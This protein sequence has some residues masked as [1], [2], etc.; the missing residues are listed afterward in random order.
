[1]GR[2]VED[3]SNLS[4]ERGEEGEV[5]RGTSTMSGGGQ[6]GRESRLTL[7]VNRVKEGNVVFSSLIEI[8]LMSFP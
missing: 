8:F 3:G 6:I 2:N 5:E 7:S 1:M 4:E